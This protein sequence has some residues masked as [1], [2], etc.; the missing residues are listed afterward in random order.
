MRA[1]GFFYDWSGKKKLDPYFSQVATAFAELGISLEIILANELLHPAGGQETTNP[2]VDP[3]KLSAWVK[4]R[5]PDF[6]FSVNNAGM[7]A[8]IA[9]ATTVPIITWLVDDLPHLFFHDGFGNPDRHFH[10]QER[11]FCY[12]STLAEQIRRVFP[13]AR[14]R[15]SW[16]SHGTNLA[17]Q[18][19]SDQASIYPISFVGSCFPIQPIVR[20]LNNSRQYGASLEVLE[21]LKA[22]DQDYVAG[23]AMIDT[24]SALDQSLKVSGTSFFQYHRMLADTLTTQNRTRGLHKVADLGLHLWGSSIWLDTLNYTQQV[25]NCFEFDTYI[26]SSDQLTETY[27]KSRISINIPNVQNCAGLAARVLD[28]M[29]SSS[30]LITEYH[31]ESDLFTL[32]GDNCPVPMYRSFDHLREIC[33]YYLEH[34]AERQ[35]IV[36]ACNRLVDDRFLLRNRLK[37]MLEAAG[38]ALA[39]RPT[40]AQPFRVTPATRFYGIPREWERLSP[41]ARLI[42]KK[43]ARIAL[44]PVLKQRQSR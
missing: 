32:F 9:A 4:Q 42:G 38:I 43:V 5:Q 30:L 31:P 14:D 41:W 22:M 10:G 12:S 40:P 16:I 36:R 21:H 1:I 27:N 37:T 8:Q 28:V 24:S 23:S 7:T 34:E 33:L 11:I 39:V 29:A 35:S 6:I 44:H 13:H 20:L 25:A 15:V 26:T 18:N 2:L 3:A 17:G 19:L